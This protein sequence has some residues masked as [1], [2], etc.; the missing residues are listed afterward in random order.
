MSIFELNITLP[1]KTIELSDIIASQ[2]TRGD[3]LCLRGELGTGKTFISRQIIQSITNSSVAVTSPTFQILQIYQIEK[4]DSKIYHY[5][6]YRLKHY[7]EIYELGIEDAFNPENI[8]IIEWPEI[9][10]QILPQNRIDIEIFMD[11]KE[12]KCIIKDGSEK[13]KL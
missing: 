5:D 7:E 8:C 12:R 1:Q 6:L 13:L 10:E 4:S 3:I 9:I 11:G 2:I